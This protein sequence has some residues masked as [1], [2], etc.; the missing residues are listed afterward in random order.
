M[1]VSAKQAEKCNTTAMRS[2]AQNTSDLIQCAA[3][4]TSGVCL[5]PE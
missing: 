5:V 4:T 3:S 2:V 1:R